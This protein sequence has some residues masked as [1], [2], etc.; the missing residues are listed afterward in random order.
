MTNK[1]F[2]AAA[3]AVAAAVLIFW[4]GFLMGR[5]GFMTAQTIECEQVNPATQTEAQRAHCYDLLHDWIA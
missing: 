5:V 1:D 4:C 3:V 2:D